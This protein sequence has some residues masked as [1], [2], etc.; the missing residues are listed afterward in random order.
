MSMDDYCNVYCSNDPYLDAGAPSSE[1]EIISGRVSVHGIVAYVK[2]PGV[3]AD[4]MNQRPMYLSGQAGV[5]PVFKFVFPD[6]GEAR[7]VANYPFYNGGNGTLFED[8]VYFGADAAGIVTGG[9]T[10]IITLLVFFTGGALT[11]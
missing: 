5:D 6:F 3:A 4:V 2:G 11:P 9:N 1:V 10:S 8:G 7:L